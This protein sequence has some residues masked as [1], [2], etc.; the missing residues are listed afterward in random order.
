MPQV[1][2][3]PDVLD[4]ALDFLRVQLALRAEPYAAGVTTGSYLPN[5]EP[6]LPFIWMRRVGGFTTGR[7]TDRARLDVHVY[8]ED[9]AQT[10]DLT[11]LVRGLLL[12]WPEF[13]SSIAK[14]AREFSGPGP[15][16][17][18]LWPAAVRFYF[19]VEIYLRGLVA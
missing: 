19:T 2:V 4:G 15:V 17:D 18:D 10:H 3:Y 1:I 7:A 8:H 12:A 6:D 13:D 16:P 9:E 11:Q 14:G 5:P